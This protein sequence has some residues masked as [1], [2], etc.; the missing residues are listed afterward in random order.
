L[1]SL[2]EAVRYGYKDFGWMLEDG[3]LDSVR[4]CDPFRDWFT[5]VAPPSIADRAGLSR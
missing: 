3:D 1:A 4:A 2:R 5:D